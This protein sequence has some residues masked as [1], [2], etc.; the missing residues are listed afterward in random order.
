[1]STYEA[2]YEDAKDLLEGGLATVS[3]V[4]DLATNFT[5]SPVR[6]N[7]PAYYDGMWAAAHAFAL[8]NQSLNH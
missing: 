2:G 3:E 4:K 6:D 1:M 5:H 8:A 7:P